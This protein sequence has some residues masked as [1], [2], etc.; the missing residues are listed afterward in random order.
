MITSVKAPLGTEQ[1]GLNGVATVEAYN[2]PTA[3]GTDSL[4]YFIQSN[5]AYEAF[6]HYSVFSTVEQ[7][8]ETN[9]GFIPKGSLKI[10]ISDIEFVYLGK[11]QGFYFFSDV[12]GAFRVGFKDPNTNQGVQD[13]RVQLQGLGIYAMGLVRLVEYINTCILKEITEP[14]YFVTRVDLNIFCQFDL[15]SVI[16][17]EQIA[18]R[19][20]KFS[21]VIGTK[22]RYETFY[23]GKPPA[24]IRIYDK[25]LE[26]DKTSEKFYYMKLYF[27]QF[28]IKMKDPLWNFEIE[29]HRDFLKQYKISTLD[30]LLANVQTLFHKCMEQVRLVDISTISEKDLEA[31]RLY[32]A[33]THPLW[34]YLDSS[35]TFNATTQN[36]IPLERVVY[37]PKELTSNDFIEDF[38]AL[39]HKYSEHAVIV[40]HDEVRAVLHESR[41]WLTKEAK[42]ILK[43]FIPIVLQTDERNYLLTRNFVAVPTLPKNLKHISDAQLQQ[44]SELLTKALH[45]ELAK[46]KQDIELIIKHAKLVNEEMQNRR[47][48]QKE[49]ELWQV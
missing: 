42:K 29:C 47:V 24:R 10:I 2:F 30:D 5:S 23:I 14:F 28:G 27:E 21:R 41:L 9:G 3:S 38:R 1:E 32:K 26:L 45:Q 33:Q 46:D 7:A 31:N 39:V 11:E 36:T 34:E 25:F 49:L 43:P 16:Q 15:G 13:I 17:P 44:L 8:K 48:G 22:N 37:A 18:T 35:Y 6:Y 40:N 12:A 19:K 4:Y 20:R